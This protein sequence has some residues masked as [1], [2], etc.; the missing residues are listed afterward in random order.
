MIGSERDKWTE[1]GIEQNRERKIVWRKRER[2]TVIGRFYF[3]I[4]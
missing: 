4:N 2:E 1:K 3:G